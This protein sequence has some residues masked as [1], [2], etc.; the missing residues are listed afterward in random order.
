MR[1]V[2]PKS[3]EQQAAPFLHRARDLIVRQRTQLSDMLRSLLAEFGVGF[4]L[5]GWDVDPNVDP[6]ERVSIEIYI[7]Y[8]S[9]GLIE[10]CPGEAIY[11]S[12]L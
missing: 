12:I 11:C 8:N 1:L 3:E 5:I 2:A 10:W 4:Y 7:Y 6:N 9:L